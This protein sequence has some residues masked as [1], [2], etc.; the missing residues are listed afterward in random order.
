MRR[1]I[2]ICSWKGEHPYLGNKRDLI[3]SSYHHLLKSK[4]LDGTRNRRI[5]HLIYVLTQR[6]LPDYYQSRHDRQQVGLEGW[7][8]KEMHHLTILSH[9]KSILARSITQLSNTV[10]HVASQ[11]SLGCIYVVDTQA[12]ICDC[13][14]FPR[15]QFCKHLAAVQTHITQISESGPSQISRHRAPELAS[16]LEGL[17]I[18]CAPISNPGTQSEHLPKRE[19]LSPNRNLWNDTSKNMHHPSKR[20]RAQDSSNLTTE[21]IGPVGKHKLVF[22]N[23]YSGGERPGKRAKLD[24]QSAA[25]NALAIS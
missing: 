12:L 13:L 1:V 15:I 23:P 4:W 3:K 11:T 9:S 14:D 25:A 24:A 21:H 19:R 17:P 16:T 2:Q 20:R 22:N 18:S 10:F 8:L 5:D 6:V 7:N